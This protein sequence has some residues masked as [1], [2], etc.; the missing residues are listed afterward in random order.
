M[1]HQGW[2]APFRV[3]AAVTSTNPDLPFVS[4]ATRL[5]LSREPGVV[6]SCARTMSNKS[7]PSR[8]EEM[9]QSPAKSGTVP[10]VSE[11]FILSWDAQGVEVRV[12]DY[13][14][15]PLKL[16]WSMVLDLAQRAGTTITTEALETLE[17]T[18][19]ASAAEIKQAHRDLLKVWRPDRFGRSGRLRARV[20]AK[21]KRINQAY[22]TL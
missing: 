17:L 14:T 1:V 22:Q 6:S 21:L 11:G 12:T 18:A 3:G 16:P 5:F 2:Q 20:Q 19:A 7:G 9:S 15:K 8:A 10:F 4:G 13:H